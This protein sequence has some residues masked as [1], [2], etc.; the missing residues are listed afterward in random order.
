MSIVARAAVFVDVLVVWSAPALVEMWWQ[1]G[2]N[3]RH[4]GHEAVYSDDADLSFAL[5][6][7]KRLGQMWWE[8]VVRAWLR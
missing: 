6:C 2:A 4:C 7:A 3:G 8:S 1:L 5:L